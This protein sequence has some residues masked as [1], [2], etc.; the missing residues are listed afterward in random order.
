M[1]ING[2][3][4]FVK[5][6]LHAIEIVKVMLNKLLPSHLLRSKANLFCEPKN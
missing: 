6:K 4:S 1:K 3:Y 2:R 5:K